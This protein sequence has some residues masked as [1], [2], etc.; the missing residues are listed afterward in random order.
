MACKMSKCK[1][2][3][4]YRN[5]TYTP[6]GIGVAICD[7]KESKRYNMPYGSLETVVYEDDS[8]RYFKDKNQMSLFDGDLI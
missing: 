6:T 4:Y 3:K 2:C 8:C 1:D 7:M 5:E